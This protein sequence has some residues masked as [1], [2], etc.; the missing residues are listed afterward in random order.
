[1]DGLSHLITLFGYFIHVTV[2]KIAMAVMSLQ[3]NIFCKQHSLPIEVL[4]WRGSLQSPSS[5]CCITLSAVKLDSGKVRLMK[6]WEGIFG[7]TIEQIHPWELALRKKS[8]IKNEE[9][10]VS[11]ENIQASEWQSRKLKDESK[12][13]YCL[14]RVIIGQAMWYI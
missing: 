12:I 8:M 14:F 11:L 4:S 6:I 10:H 9:K 13:K 5:A 1:M 3:Q 7:G 2:E